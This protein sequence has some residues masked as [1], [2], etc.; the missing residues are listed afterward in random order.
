M[1]PKWRSLDW[2]WFTNE[3]VWTQF[4]QIGSQTRP[5]LRKTRP[6]SIE[7]GLGLWDRDLNLGPKWVPGSDLGLRDLRKMGLGIQDWI[8]KSQ[9]LK[10][11]GLRRRNHLV[12]RSQ[13]DVSE[14]IVD[15]GSQNQLGPETSIW[16]R[17]GL[18]SQMGPQTGSET[19]LD[20]RITALLEIVSKQMT[21]WA[22]RAQRWNIFWKKSWKITIFWKK[23]SFFRIFGKSLI[24]R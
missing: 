23:W 22:Q 2:V 8:R 4:V 16:A 14:R 15:L 12:L 1:R 19:K 10:F 17:S 6:N 3:S 13:I 7:L 11:S 18:G 20:L 5:G 24:I 9:F 21:L